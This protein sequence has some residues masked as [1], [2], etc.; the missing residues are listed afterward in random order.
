MNSAAPSQ[1]A[2][3]PLLPGQVSWRWRILIASYLA[4]GGFYLTRK[5]FTICKTTIAKDLGWQL[6]DTAHIWTA[7]LVAYMLGM[8]LNSFIG[9]RWGPRV[10]LLGGLALSMACNVVFGFANSFPTFIAFM[11][12]NGLVQACG[13]PG[14]VGTVAEWLRPAER[15]RIMGVWS[16]N[17]LFG[18]ML[19]KSLGGFLLGAYGWRW[20]F[21]GCTL[22]T[23]AVWWL[24]YFWQRNR[25]A[26]V[27]LEPIV[28]QR[29]EETRAVQA[30]QADRVTFKDYARLA[31]N[32]IILAMGASYFCIKFLRYALDSWLPAFLNI[33]GLDVAHASYYS[34]VFDFAGVGGVFLAGWALDRWFKG[35]WAAVGAVMGLG[36]IVGYAAV[37]KFGGSP[38]AIAICFGV[39]GFMLYGPDTLLCG[40]ASVQVAGEKNAVA[41]AGLVNGMGSIGSVVQEQVI[42]WLVRGDVHRG[43]RN[44]NLLA[45]SV[46]IVMA[47]LLAAI[48]WRLHVLASRRQA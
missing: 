46:S 39:V 24:V 23:F 34:Q 11:V 3:K 32:P 15:G 2:L 12:F 40:A 16:T 14:S 4:Y 13:W 1:P 27:G 42:G 29:G 44:T 10:L 17:Y 47:I 6:G 43:M 18:N 41:V 8:F 9:R 33:Q 48:A 20:S 25:P 30:S 45:L 22:I 7:F 37:I 5:V 38:G 21:F 35:N 26:D 31:T 19:V 28:E 36:V